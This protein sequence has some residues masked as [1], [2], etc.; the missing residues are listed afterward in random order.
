M[1]DPVREGKHPK[2]GSVWSAGNRLKNKELSWFK[3]WRMAVTSVRVR[4]VKQMASLCVQPTA[5]YNTWTGGYAEPV[6]SRKV[7]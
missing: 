5:Y 1:N 2:K 7:V 3:S 6:T 4:Q